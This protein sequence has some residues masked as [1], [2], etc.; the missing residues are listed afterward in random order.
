M[1][2]RRPPP[3]GKVVGDF[4]KAAG[5]SDAA[6]DATNRTGLWNEEIHTKNRSTYDYRVSAICKGHLTARC[7]VATDFDWSNLDRS[8]YIKQVADL[9]DLTTV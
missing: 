7:D 3:P 5:V 2:V 9:I 4:K 8:Y 6:Y 1:S